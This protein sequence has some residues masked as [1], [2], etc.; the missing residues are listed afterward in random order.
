MK[1]QINLDGPEGNAW[2]M[3]GLAT[4]WGR[5]LDLDTNK[6]CEEMRAS[7]YDNLCRVF[8]KYFGEVAVLIKDGEVFYPLGAEE[9]K[10]E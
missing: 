8:L 6:I 9:Y 4:K 2:N 7:D 3:M 5:Q 10:D 1:P